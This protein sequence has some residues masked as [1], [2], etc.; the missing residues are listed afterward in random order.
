M[1]YEVHGDPWLRVAERILLVALQDLT[2]PDY[3]DEFYPIRRAEAL[4]WLRSPD[5]VSLAIELGYDE[6]V[7]KLLLERRLLLPLIMVVDD[8]GTGTEI[9]LFLCPSCSE[10]DQPILN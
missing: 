4:Q 7:H 10:N 3:V 6:E 8:T 9:P 2:E 5:G 1:P